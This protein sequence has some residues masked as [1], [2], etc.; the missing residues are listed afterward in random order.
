M[1]QNVIFDLDGTLL[2]HHPGSGG[3]RQLG[4]PPERLA[5]ALGGGIQE[6]GGQWH[7]QPGAAVLP[8]GSRSSLLLAN[9]IAQFSE[10]YGAHNLD[11]TR[12]MRASRSFW[13]AWGSGA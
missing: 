9:T 5:G 13:P 6:D 12:P 1:Y 4:L 8:E 10:Y 2:E 11:K 3:R 7:P